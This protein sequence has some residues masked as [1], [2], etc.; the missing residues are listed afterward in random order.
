[1]YHNPIEMSIG[2]AIEMSV[3]TYIMLYQRK[4]SSGLTMNEYISAITTVQQSVGNV[5]YVAPIATATAATTILSSVIV[6]VVT[7]IIVAAIAVIAIVIVAAVI[8]VWL[9]QPSRSSPERLL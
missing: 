6:A 7:V 2:M 9:P 8:V 3:I 5:G 1:V 4:I